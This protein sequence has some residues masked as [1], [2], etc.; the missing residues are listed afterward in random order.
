MYSALS[1]TTSYDMEV[2]NIF[3]PP[4]CTTS[5]SDGGATVQESDHVTVELS[6]A[7]TDQDTLYRSSVEKYVVGSRSNI[8]AL[9][10]GLAGMCLG[11]R[12][13]IIAPPALAYGVA[14]AGTL[15]PLV[16]LDTFQSVDDPNGKFTGILFCLSV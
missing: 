4:G 11:S 3:D 6:I 8:V 16:G 9:N 13:K 14:G 5:S 7:T 12:R 1:V 10:E 15:L 2:I